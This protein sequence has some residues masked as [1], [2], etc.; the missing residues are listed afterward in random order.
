MELGP[1]PVNTVRLTAKILAFNYDQEQITL[2]LADGT[3]RTV[4]VRAGVN[5]GNY[6]VGDTVSVFITEAMT[7]A[8]EKQ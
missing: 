7:I 6:N 4:T 8:L 3:T 5:L 2:Q 1:K